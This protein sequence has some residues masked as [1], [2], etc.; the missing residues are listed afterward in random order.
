MKTTAGTPAIGTSSGGAAAPLGRGAKT[1]EAK[2]V[3][4]Y[5]GDFHAVEDVTMTIAPTR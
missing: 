4:L 3:N 5:Y 1:I 2:G